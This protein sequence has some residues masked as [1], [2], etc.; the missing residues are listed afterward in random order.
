MIRVKLIVIFLFLASSAKLMAQEIYIIEGDTLELIREVN[1]T[2]SLLWSREG[3]DYRYFLQ[4]G[5]K[6]LELKNERKDDNSKTYQIQ[7]E[8]LTE[9]AGLS[10]R[11][12]KFR[13][14]SLKHFTNRY[15]ASVQ[16]DYEYNA[17]SPNIRQRVGL[18]TGLS[19][20]PYSSNP[21][22]MLTPVLGLEYELYDPN[23]APR[24]SVFFHLRQSFKSSEYNYSSMQLSLNYRVKVLYLKKFDVH[25]DTELATLYYST[26]DVY[27]RNDAGEIIEVQ[28]EGGLDFT[29][30]LSFGIGADIRISEHGFITFSYN[31]I[32]SVVLDSNGSFL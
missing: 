7:L 31:D 22:N 32:V 25:L 14:Y 24:H 19:N 8:E 9:G 13:L 21:E 23:L 26:G 28:E 11:D 2:L 30:P 4:K 12:V 17:A 27:I 5:K 10:V 6:V 18:F 3:N 29:A 16:E 20:N 15:N 1:G